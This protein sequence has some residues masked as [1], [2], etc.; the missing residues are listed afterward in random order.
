MAQ[1]AEKTTKGCD[2]NCGSNANG[3]VASSGAVYG[4]GLFGAL[5]FYLSSAGSFMDVVLGIIKS[6]VWP[7]MMVYHLFKFLGM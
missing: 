5:Y 1:E 3:A 2:C 4:F 6:L 7:G